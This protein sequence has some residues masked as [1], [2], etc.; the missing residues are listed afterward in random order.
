MSRTQLNSGWEFVKTKLGTEYS[1]GLGFK[2]VSIP[3]DWLIYDTNDLYEDSTGWY[4]KKLDIPD[5]GL[6]TALRFEGVYMDSRLYVNG[7][8]AYEHKYGYTTFEA[9]ITDFLKAGE[10]EITVRVD[11][12]EPNSRWYSGAGIYRDV[13]LCRYHNEHI[14]P[15]G[16]YI[17]AYNDGRVIVSVEAERG[18]NVPCE[19]LK[20]RSS[21][22]FGEQLCG[23]NEYECTAAD[24]SLIPEFL[25]RAGCRYSV[26]E[27]R[28]TI[29]SPKLWDIESPNLYRCVCELI[30]GGEV[31]DTAESRFGFRS[32]EFTADR[33]FL[34]NGRQVKIHG[35]CEHHDFGA[36]GAVF[37]KTAM[38]RKLVKLRE[39]GINAVRTSHNPPAPGLLE[40]ADEMGFLILD[41][42]FDM[43]EICKTKYD[44]ARFFPEWAEKDAA[45]WVRRDRNF[46]CIIGWS[47]GNEIY[48]TFVAERGQEVTSML[49]A[50]VRRHDYRGNASVTIASNYMK[51]KHAQKC[52]D[53]LKIAGYNYSESLYPE[54]HEAHPDWAI[55]GS[56]TSSVVAS[57]GIYHFPAEQE[58]LCEENEQCSSLGNSFPAWAAKGW[59]ACILPDRDARYCAGQFI[60]TGFDYIGEPTPYETKSSYFGQI[61]TAGFCKDGAYVFRSAWT[62][63][64]KAP[65]VHLFPHWDWNEGEVID[66]FAATN[67]PKCVLFFNGEKIAEQDIDHIHGR[68]LMLHKKLAYAKGELTAVAYDENGNEVARDTRRSFGDTVRLEVTPDKTVLKADGKD[69]I[70]LE[71]SALDKDG[72]F[73]ANANDRVRVE[74]TG[75]GRLAGLDNGDSTDYEQYKGI[76]RRLFSGKLLAVIAAKNVCGEIKVRLTSPALEPVELTLEAV[77][78]GEN[79][80]ITEIPEGEENTERPLDCTCPDNDIPVRK[81]ELSGEERVFTPEKRVLSFGVKLYPENAVYRDLEFK[82]TTDNGI[83]VSTGKVIS[84]DGERVT[85]ECLGDGE[86]CLRA[87]TKNGT[88]KIR[89]FSSLK[90]RGEGLGKALTDPYEEVVCGLS[91][92]SS[93]DIESGLTKGICFGPKGGY[94]G[95]E[96]LDFGDKGSDTIEFSIFANS[97]TPVHMKVYDGRPD[98]GGE[99][100]GDLEYHVEPK[101]MVFNPASFRLR[102]VLTGVHTLVFESCDMIDLHSF[103]FIMK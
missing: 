87:F 29:K 44:Y 6:R 76:S 75:A 45:L 97:F 100:I 69:L 103:R 34:L 51:G 102:K 88:D 78:A 81:I 59:A 63:Y 2:P 37:S 66:I 90:L 22:Y 46:P 79:D 94:F 49:K 68:E 18:E 1:K 73:V 96:E 80:L 33:G 60:W 93:G 26:N 7:V 17:S 84:Y 61:D 14:L 62:D 39:M 15:D 65:F 8:Q 13:W 56:E 70:F 32:A 40:L 53:I 85:V 12:K 25:R 52:A 58:I 91:D 41:E 28:F 21:V 31:I 55:F 23:V 98:F 36:L 5:D 99:L 67:V 42:G 16:V 38:R 9:D 54:Q 43:W 77:S 74:V 35:C 86:F 72:E 19:E 11:H 82:L 92:I 24:I 71:I 64:K 3:H 27:S 30:K 20:V 47:I 48:D 83:K 50:Y 89:L 57:R 95:F 10:N 4:R 101:W